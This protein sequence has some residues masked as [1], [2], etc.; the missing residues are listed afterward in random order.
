MDT[1]VIDRL[2]LELSQVTK[3]KTN[4]ELLLEQSLR[5][6]NE[7]L[8]SCHAISERKGENTNW[9]FIRKALS[10][11]LYNHLPIINSFDKN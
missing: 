6:S 3:A 5:E 4:R 2:Y 10:K 1:E 11:V 9:E 7:L 8:R